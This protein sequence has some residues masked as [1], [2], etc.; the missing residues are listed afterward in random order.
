LILI[1]RSD[2]DN[3]LSL[4]IHPQD[5]GHNGQVLVDAT[6][7]AHIIRAVIT[8]ALECTN[9]LGLIWNICSLQSAA[10]HDRKPLIKGDL[11]IACEDE[12]IL[13][14]LAGDDEAVLPQSVVGCN[15]LGQVDYMLGHPSTHQ[16][17]FVVL[18]PLI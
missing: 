14:L 2:I 1:S 13:R 3:P 9:S 7:H 12:N 16:T 6:A 18:T 15:A 11:I 8:H 17:G 5:V 10:V 4:L